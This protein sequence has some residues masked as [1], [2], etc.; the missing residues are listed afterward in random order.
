MLNVKGQEVLNKTFSTNLE[1]VK[2]EKAIK[3]IST[4]TN[5]K[6]NYSTG[7]INLNTLVSYKADNKRIIDF[8]NEV[9]IPNGISYQEVNGSIV[10]FLAKKNTLNNEY[11]RDHLNSISVSGYVKDS[12]GNPLFGVTVKLKGSNISTITD[13]NG[14]YSINTNNTNQLLIFSYVGYNNIEKKLVRIIL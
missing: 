5:V 12:I 1:N 2:I 8:I 10:L 7:S 6:F 9:L 11:L 3:T 14:H 4:I 13:N